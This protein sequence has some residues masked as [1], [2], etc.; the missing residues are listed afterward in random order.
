MHNG[1]F[2]MKDRFPRSRHDEVHD[3]TV[4][5]EPKRALD[6]QLVPGCQY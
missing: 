1:M 3:L 5:T 2:S 4:S 6:V